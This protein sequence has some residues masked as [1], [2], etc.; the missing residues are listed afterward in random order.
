MKISELPEE[1]KKKAL[2]NQKNEN[3]FRTFDNTSD[4]LNKAFSW[5]DTI[6]GICFWRY[7]HM[8]KNNNDTSK[9]D[10]FA[11]VTNPY[12]KN[13]YDS[14]GVTKPEQYQIGIDTFA[15]AE[16]NLTKDQI[17]SICKFNI[18]KY[19]WRQ[20]NQDKEDFKKIIDYAN[21]ALKNL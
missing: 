16:A 8:K 20:K 4:Y 19:N 7:W 9:N 1:I 3:Y 2:E 15:R 13:N 18:D 14:N 5:E 11:T 6:D 21:W 17:I 10:S 12:V